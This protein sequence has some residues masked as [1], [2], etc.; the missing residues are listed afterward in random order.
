MDMI[1]EEDALVAKNA[2]FDEHALYDGVKASTFV[3]EQ[4]D[5]VS[6]RSVRDTIVL[7]ED[8]SDNKLFLQR[9]NVRNE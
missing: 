4:H 1:N 8:R 2:L 7:V 6:R 3:R 5:N 9:C